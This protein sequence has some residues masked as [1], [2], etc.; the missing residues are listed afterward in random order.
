VGSGWSYRRFHPEH[1]VRC[2]RQHRGLPHRSALCTITQS[3][4]FALARICWSMSTVRCV[5]SK[6]VHWFAICDD[7]VVELRVLTCCSGDSF[8]FTRANPVPDGMKWTA[9][10]GKD[11]LTGSMC[12]SAHASYSSVASSASSRRTFHMRRVAPPFLHHIVSKLG[13]SAPTPALTGRT[14]ACT[15][16][17]PPS[18]GPPRNPSRCRTP[19]RR[20]TTPAC[21]SRSAHPMT[22][23]ASRG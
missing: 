3:N 19:A 7:A 11:T 1:V 2:W 8:S 9:F 16:A 5:D 22:G 23:G 6:S 12:A 4:T 13:R 17:R 20:R 15:S 14:C 18:Y 10:E 21:R